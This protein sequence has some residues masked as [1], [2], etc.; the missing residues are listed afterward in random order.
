MC[1]V[2]GR[3]YAAAHSRDASTVALA[4]LDFHYVR[5]AYSRKKQ[6]RAARPGRTWRRAC[7]SSA[8]H[9]RQ[10]ATPPMHRGSCGQVPSLDVTAAIGLSN[11]VLRYA[12]PAKGAT[13][14]ACIS[15][16][17]QWSS[18]RRSL[19]RAQGQGPRRSKVLALLKAANLRGLRQHVSRQL[20]REDT[21]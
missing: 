11:D 15:A 19:T 20:Y 8:L 13:S 21:P 2:E 5:L 14:R 4:L 7:F 3:L 16:V 18:T 12:A 1:A 17:Y 6:L 9:A 10:L